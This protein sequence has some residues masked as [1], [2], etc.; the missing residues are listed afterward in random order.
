MLEHILRRM[1]FG[2]SP[3]DLAYYGDL[4]PLS[5]VNTLLN[6]EQVPDDVDANIGQPGFVGVT[7]RGQFSPD[8]VINDA[9]QRWLFR[10][11][12]SRAAAPGEDGALLAQPLRHGLQQGRRARSAAMQRHADDGRQAAE[13]RRRS[14]ARFELFREL[15]HGQLPRPAG[16]GG[17]GPGDARAGST[18]A[19]TSRTRPQ[20]NFAPRADGA[21]HHGHRPLHR[22][23]RLRRGARLHGLEPASWPATAPTGEPATTGS[24]TTPNQHD[25]TAKEFTL[26]DLP[27]RRPRRSPRDRRPQ[28]MQDGIDLI[29]A[30]ARH[31]AT[32]R[33]PGAHGSTSSSSAMSDEPDAGLRERSRAGLPGEQLQHQGDAAARCWC[34]SSSS[35]GRQHFRRYAW[36]VEFVV[37][38][39]KEVG[40]RGL[41]VRFGHHPARQHG[42]AAA[43][44]RPT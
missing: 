15:R 38:A 41:S 37:R 7:T 23:R 3:E 12:H 16:R 33:A 26:R 42:P 6:Y 22:S 13:R 44:S 32:A 9:R 20:E 28:G 40:W 14:A 35:S 17:E 8:T 36:P 31:P 27:G 25:T 24:S 39:I 5:L 1:G 10:M 34:P 21:V 4:S 43:T 19:S 30:L 11:V 2:A 29:D 18:A